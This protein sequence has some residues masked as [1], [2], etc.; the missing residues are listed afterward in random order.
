MP[1]FPRD[2]GNVL[3]VSSSNVRGHRPFVATPRFAGKRA[4]YVF[5]RREAGQGYYRDSRQTGESAGEVLQ[6]ML[7]GTNRNKHLDRRSRR[8]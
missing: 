4:G 5:T 6:Q 2:Y 7:V 8:S 3:T 1:R